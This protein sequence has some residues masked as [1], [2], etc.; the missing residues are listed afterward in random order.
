MGSWV[1]VSMELTCPVLVCMVVMV[2]IGVESTEEQDAPY[3]WSALSFLSSQNNNKR[4]A[5]DSKESSLSQA[6]DMFGSESKIEAAALIASEPDPES[7]MNPY[8]RR[9]NKYRTK[10][11]KNKYAAS[12]PSQDFYEDKIYDDTYYDRDSS[13][14]APTSGY[15]PPSDTYDAPSSYEAP[16][17]EAPSPSYEAP[18]YEAPSYEAPSYDPPSYKPAPSYE[19]PSYSGGYDFDNSLA[20]QNVSDSDY[21]KYDDLISRG[22][23]SYRAFG[24]NPIS[25]SDS[26]SSN[27]YEYDYYDDTN[28][29]AQPHDKHAE[30]LLSKAL[31]YIGGGFLGRNDNCYDEYC[32]YYEDSNLLGYG[33]PFEAVSHALRTLL[34]LGLLMA[35]LVPSTVTIPG[36]RKRQAEDEMYNTLESSYPF[37]DKINTMGFSRLSETD[38]QK[39]LFCEMAEMGSNQEANT[40]Q[41]LFAYAVSLTPDFLADMVGVKD[42]FEATREGRCRK[43]KCQY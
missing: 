22:G 25:K 41:K 15:K 6:D 16:A 32:D 19:A 31:R 26:V 40:V 43:F 21:W 14:S 10:K 38:C 18:S 42:V 37:M 8:R 36:R 29:L 1:L 4:S 33:S 23:Y 39:E 27:A 24:S 7:R 13:Y 9:K 12:V 28:L 2:V 30:T 20:Q 11:R 5:D 3:S 34:P 17:Y 35:S